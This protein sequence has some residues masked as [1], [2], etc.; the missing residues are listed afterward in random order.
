MDDATLQH[1]RGAGAIGES[2]INNSMMRDVDEIGSMIRGLQGDGSCDR[3]RFYRRFDPIAD[4][5]LA[6]RQDLCAEAAA[7]NEARNDAPLGETLQVG[8]RLTQTDAAEPD[9]ADPEFPPDQMIQRGSAGHDIPTR[10][11]VRDRDLVVSGHR[12][13][14]L[15]LDER[16]FPRRT[17]SIGVRPA[18]I[19][20]AIPL[21]SFSRYSTDALDRPHRRFRRTRDVD[22]DDFARP[23]G[24]VSH[25]EDEGTGRYNRSLRSI[26][27]DRVRFDF[28]EHVR[29]DETADLDEGRHRTDVVEELRVRPAD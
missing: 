21:E 12:L 28:D 25:D 20:V 15:G 5:D 14:R 11:A 18:R 17:R 1:G 22:R 19:E 27:N 3:H 24:N 23:L 6:L 13:D 2:L 29:V 8:A 16:D 10:R 26:G 7:V 9:S 4:V